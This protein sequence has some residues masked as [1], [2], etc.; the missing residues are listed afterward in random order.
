MANCI[1]YTTCTLAC[2]ALSL[3][4]GITVLILS[5]FF[6][7]RRVSAREQIR[8][9]DSY[10]VD[11]VCSEIAVS[12]E[13]SMHA[14]VVS[15]DTF[16]NNSGIAVPTA[17]PTYVNVNE[18]GDAPVCS[19]ASVSTGTLNH[20][21]AADPNRITV[22]SEIAVSTENSMHAAVVSSRYFH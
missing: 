19:E 13:N 7:K 8:L 17:D 4:I 11:A 15:P 20:A 6:C 14:A 9:N 22:C 10:D 18:L 5:L 12:T 2:E 21:A 16:T 3:A 1:D